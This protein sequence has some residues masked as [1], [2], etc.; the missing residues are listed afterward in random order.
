MLIRSALQ[1]GW[2]LVDFEQWIRA[3]GPQGRVLIFR[4]DVDQHPATALRMARIE[5]KH[6]VR[7]TWYF[8]WRTASP[9][10]I[11]KVQELGGTIGLHYETLTR[12]VLERGLEADDIDAALVAEARDE[13]A[14]EVTAFAERFGPIRSIAA[15]G[16]TRVPGVS[17]QV[18]LEGLDAWQLGVQFDAGEALSRHRLG[19]WMTDRTSIEGRWKDGVDPQEVLRDT[20]D[21]VLCLTH[22]NNWCSGASLWSD[23]ARAALRNRRRPGEVRGDARARGDRPPRDHTISPPAREV[24]S[25]PQLRAAPAVRSFAPIAV[26]LRREILRHYYDG[27]KRLT[28]DGGL[29]TLDTNSALAEGRAE[30]LERALSHA[31]VL[32]VRDRHVVDLGCGFGALALVFA[33]RGARVTALDPN[34]P[35]LE[36]GARV[37][38]EYQLGVEWIVGGMDSVEFGR[39]QF[40]LAVMNNSFCYLVQPERRRA[41]LE[42]TL[43]ALRPGGVLV[44]RDPKRLRLRDQFTRIPLIGLL[45]PGAARR[46]TR[47]LRTNRS[48]VRL[49]W[50][51]VARRELRRV[52]FVEVE[53]VPTS[54]YPF[55]SKALSGYRHVVARRPLR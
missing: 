26:A 1:E 28:G 55:F 35:R 32:S 46:V 39:E 54:A 29:R 9:R 17:N 2:T 37:S 47:L 6:D 41:A 34:R 51:P 7:S 43:N 42:R 38:D 23:R 13:L 12:L 53:I 25:A 3:G 8:R 19:L 22:P 33:S 5:T 49:Q 36:V 18:L 20:S 50:G 45:P 40:D 10:A 48:D 11:A 4:H 44:M 21:P 30:T 31:G 52:G 14:R 15:H 24:V 16:D 27:G